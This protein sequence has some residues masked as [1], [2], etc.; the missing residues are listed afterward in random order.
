MP[1]V[2]AAAEG[3]LSTEAMAENMNPS[4]CHAESL[5]TPSGR[6]ENTSPQPHRTLGKSRSVH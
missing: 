6:K 5:V 2:R 1:L 4:H 3:S